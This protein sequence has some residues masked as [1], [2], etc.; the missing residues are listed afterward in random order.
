MTT[1][2]H[3]TVS[4]LTPAELEF[5]RQALRKRKRVKCQ[6][7]ERLI[8]ARKVARK[9]A[10]ILKEQFGVKKVVLFGSTVRPR[11]FHI[12]SDV[13]LAVWGLDEKE[14]FRTLGVLLGIDYE[15]GVD[16]IEFEF[17]PPSMQKVILR[18]GKP[19]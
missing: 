19:L 15:V 7:P 5:Y 11:L 18:D 17:A 10:K 1:T 12:R 16:L 4:E 9:A 3:R 2:L 8:R 14:Y 6:A 13:D